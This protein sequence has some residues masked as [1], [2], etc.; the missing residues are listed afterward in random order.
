[1]RQKFFIFIFLFGMIALLIGLNAASYAP[2]EKSPD[3]ESLP[4]RSTFNTGSTGLQA[5]Y[6]L[7]A[8][9]GHRVIRWQTPPAAL[10][11]AGDQ[12]PGVYVV[13]GTLRK[14]FTPGESADLLRWVSDG[15]ILVLIDREPPAEL[16]SSTA[17]WQLKAINPLDP[18]I[19]DVDPADPATMTGGVAAVTPVQ[20]SI[21]T[22]NINAVQ[23]SA[24][25]GSIE[26]SRFGVDSHDE[27]DPSNSRS[28]NM[29]DVVTPS[30]SA[31][32]VHLSDGEKQLLVD[33]PFGAGNIMVL[34]DPFIVANGG[35]SLADN[36]ILAIN[37]VDAGQ[38]IIAFDEYHQGYGTDSNRFLQ[39]F[40]GT[41]VVAIFFQAMLLIGLAFLSNSR[42]FARPVPEPGPDRLSK[43]EYVAAMAELQRRTKAYD[44]AIENI[45]SEFRRRAARLLGV[46]N[47]TIPTNELA[48]QIA[49]RV[50][51]D[52]YE[53]GAALVKCEEIIRGE[54][55]NRS[56]AVA[57]TAKIRDIESK[58]GLSRAGR[59]RI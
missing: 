8:E 12:K 40:A 32:L 56:E 33:T 30:D 13:A 2:A 3:I 6:T 55:T 52:Q 47:K 25:A 7:L 15:G 29:V 24:F 28:G 11:T 43:L 17:N 27:E 37:L 1:M 53:I 39:F 50:G 41:P 21:L 49:H 31:P 22:R 44:L 19:L 58:L 54:P 57:L 51:S 38:G 42:R 46:D 36:A 4:H 48:S 35:I 16:L 18:G 9:T 34:S 23:A 59:S 5:Y 45:Y 10:L 20:P 14:E 26:I